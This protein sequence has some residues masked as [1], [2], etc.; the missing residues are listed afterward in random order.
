[1][2]KLLAISLALLL[3]LGL[4]ACTPKGEYA[5]ER[6]FVENYI[7]LMRDKGIDREAFA[8]YESYHVPEVFTKEYQDGHETLLQMKEKP[9]DIGDVV[10]ATL[11]ESFLENSEFRYKLTEVYNDGTLRLCYDVMVPSGEKL[12]EG[13]MMALS[14]LDDETFPVAGAET[15]ALKEK[16]KKFIAEEEKLQTVLAFDVKEVDGKLKFTSENISELYGNLGA[17]YAYEIDYEALFAGQVKDTP[18]PINDLMFTV[19]GDRPLSEYREEDGVA[20]REDEAEDTTDAAPADETEDS[21]KEAAA[22]VPEGAVAEAKAYFEEQMDLLKSL[23][24]DTLAKFSGQDTETINM[25]LNFAPA[26]RSIF[27]MM[28]GHLEYTY[29]G[30]EEVS[31]NEVKLTYEIKAYEFE[32]LQ[33]YLESIPEEEAL[34]YEPKDGEIEA[35]VAENLTEADRVVQESTITMTRDGDVWQVGEFYL[36][37]LDG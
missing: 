1:M 24:I 29:L 23:D 31:D 34:T 17:A 6:K 21:G 13:E 30:G 35:W 26:M 19:T 12:F 14:E 33:P 2:K 22:D 9:A 11:Y 37:K 27:E 5:K 36:P 8:E 3:C 18:E 32:K 25:M 15:E 10:L 28:F 4:T 7:E 16:V 20:P